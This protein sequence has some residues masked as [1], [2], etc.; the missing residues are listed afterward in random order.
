M[1]KWIKKYQQHLIISCL[2]LLCIVGV[3]WWLYGL[4]YVT[5]DDAYVNANVIYIGARVNGQV[6]Q[7]NM[8]NN[9]YVKRGEVL[10]TL[11]PAMYMAI[12]EK[13]QSAVL[14]ADAKEMIEQITADRTLKL[15]SQHAASKQDGD[16]ALANL[17][18]AT[19][20]KSIA[21][22]TEK[23]SELNLQYT[24]IIAPTNGWVTNVRLRPG[25]LVTVN[26]P[27]FALVSDK[28]FWIDANFRETD[29][30]RIKVGQ[31]VKVKVDMYPNHSFNGMVESIQSGSGTV[32]S[33]LPPENATG[34]WVKVTQRIPVRIRVLN[35]DPRWLL[36]IGT[37]ATVTVYTK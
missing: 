9:Q 19:A 35:P 11:D 28:Y 33:L 2:I 7:V 26:Q 15:V 32:F 20:N 18:S 12:L 10:F 4:F 3:G 16:I 22:A 31:L 23:T 34:N 13:D 6:N 27:L 5:T 36:R 14:A 29:I 24:K 37:S 8:V 1:A 30:D 17:K 25:D 21:M